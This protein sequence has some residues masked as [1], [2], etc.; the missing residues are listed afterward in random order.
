MSQFPSP[1]IV[2]YGGTLDPAAVQQQFDQL[3]ILLHTYDKAVG[4]FFA[5]RTSALTLTA[6][7]YTALAPNTESFDYSG[8]YD[9]STGKYTPLRAGTYLLGAGPVGIDAT[10]WSA[11][12]Q[13]L[14]RLFKNGTVTH[15]LGRL[16]FHAA[17]GGSYATHVTCG[18]TEIEADGV[19]DYFEVKV[20]LERSDATNKTLETDNALANT[21]YGH[22]VGGKP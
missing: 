8:W 5:Y 14:V 11:G 22:Y 21:F 12:D 4:S 15:T 10:S 13:V 9:A 20:F 18:S 7:A 19:D 17:S 1:S 3:S 2:G 6:N 16:R